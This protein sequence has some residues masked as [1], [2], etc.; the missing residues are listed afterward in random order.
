MVTAN[1]PAARRRG[2]DRSRDRTERRQRSSTSCATSTSDADEACAVIAE[3]GCRRSTPSVAADEAAGELPLPRVIAIANQKGGVGKTTTA[4]NLGAALAE[5]GLP[6]PGR[7]PR[8]AGQR[9]DRARD[10]PPRRRGLDLRRDHERRPG[11]RLRRADEPQEPLRAPGDHRPRRR[12]D[13]ARPGVQPRAEAA[14][15]ARR[16]ARRVRL[17]AHRLP[18]VARAAHRQRA[19]RRRRRDRPD[20]VRVLRAR[21]SRASCCA[22]SRWC[23][24]TS[25][26]RSTSAGS[27]SRCTTPAPSSPSRSSTRCASTSAPK[28][29]RTVVPRTVRLSEAPSFGQPIIVFDSTSRGAMAYRELAKEVSSGATRRAG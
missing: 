7:R 22:T 4:V 18:A 6:G 24:R 16:G 11:R 25:T 2:P 8:P 15:G 9:H 23:G 10:Q 21:G 20:P 19:R 17:H 14:P 13:R 29:Y 26:R 12:R 28:V 5:L 1:P 3:P 27:C